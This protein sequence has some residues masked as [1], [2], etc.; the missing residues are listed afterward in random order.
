MRATAPIGIYY[1]LLELVGL[2]PQTRTATIFIIYLFI[3]CLFI[4]LFIVFIVFIYLLVFIYLFNL[5]YIYLICTAVP[6]RIE[7]RCDHCCEQVR[8]FFL[9]T[10]RDILVGARVRLGGRLGRGRCGA[11]L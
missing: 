1:P 6:R 7:P 8:A 3:Y 9:T 5:F 10:K 2:S 4:Y 11:K